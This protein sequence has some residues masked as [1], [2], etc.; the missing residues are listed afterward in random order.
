MLSWLLQITLYKKETNRQQGI[1][2]T[3]TTT[4]TPHWAVTGEL[5]IA[6]YHWG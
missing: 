1:N 4:T 6:F 3:T 2:I 5:K